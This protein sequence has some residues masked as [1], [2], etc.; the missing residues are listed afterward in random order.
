MSGYHDS[1]S[2]D[3]YA[4]PPRQQRDAFSAAPPSRPAHPPPSGPSRLHNPPY[5]APPPSGPSRHPSSY[6]RGH[7]SAPRGPRY[8]VGV[9]PRLYDAA[10]PPPLP[11]PRGRLSLWSTQN[12]GGRD[13]YHH[14]GGQSV[15]ARAYVP[16]AHRDHDRYDPEYRSQR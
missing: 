13:G 15:H 4:P 10:P 6:G 14:S 12:P 9:P 11:P 5:S 1:R 2:G 3:R 16:S 7:D 8:D